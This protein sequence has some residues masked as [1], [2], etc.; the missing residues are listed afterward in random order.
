MWRMPRV[1]GPVAGTVKF[2][3]AEK[4]WAAIGSDALSPRRDARGSL[5]GDCRI[6]VAGRWSVRRVSPTSAQQQ[7]S[8]D[9]VAERVR[10]I[11][12]IR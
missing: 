1:L 3:Q 8:F 5:L 6:Q 12:W 2:F 10:A 4:G 11:L 9:F 7:D